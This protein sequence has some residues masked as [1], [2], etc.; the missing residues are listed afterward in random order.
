MSR[1][2][3]AL[4][5][6]IDDY[7]RPIPSLQGC[8]NDLDAFAAYLSERVAK[9]NGVALN[10][11]T[12]RNGEATREAVIDGFR[13]HLG[14][15]RKGDVAVFCYSGHG[16]QEQAPQEF[17]TIEPDHLDETLVCFDSR[18][19][20]NWDLADKELAKLIKRSRSERAPR[21]RHPGLLSF[22]LGH[23]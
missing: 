5:V 7:P 12:L 18:N 3:Y 6:G 10:L 2:I 13:T 4:L 15:A 9:D 20:G 14:K 23:A 19:S 11:K 8:V 22:R 17:W 16:S 1:A 21:R